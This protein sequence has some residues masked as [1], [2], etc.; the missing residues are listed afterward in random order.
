MLCHAM[1]CIVWFQ[2][3]AG[4]IEDSATPEHVVTE[5]GLPEEDLK[6][7]LS[8]SLIDEDIKNSQ[9]SQTSVQAIHSTSESDTELSEHEKATEGSLRQWHLMML[10]TNRE[11][12]QKEKKRQNTAIRNGLLASRKAMLV[13]LGVVDDSEESQLVTDPNEPLPMPLEQ[14][15]EKALEERRKQR[16][17]EE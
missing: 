16:E 1:D 6:N 12:R 14:T 17:E 2:K 8:V 5:H 13:D 10:L 7:I 9:C 15:K 11:E 4:D 3:I